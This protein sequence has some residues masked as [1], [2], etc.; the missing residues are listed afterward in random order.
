[1]TD[2]LPALLDRGQLARETGLSRAG[3]DAVFR[4]LD[5][6]HLPGLRKPLVRRQD[7]ERLIVENTYRDGE[8][9]RW[10]RPPVASA[11]II[12]R[13]TE[14]GSRRFEV[15]Y[16][17][18]GRDTRTRYGGRFKTK[19]LAEARRAYI[20]AELAGRRVPDLRP[21]PDGP[22]LRPT[23]AAAAERWLASRL[24]LGP[25]S[26]SARRSACRRLVADLGERDPASLTVADV[27][28]L[29]AA[30]AKDLTPETVKAYITTL[31][32]VLDHA[33]IEPNPARDRRVRLP[34]IVREEPKPPTRREVD[35]LVEALP[36]RFRLPV[37]LMEATGL[38]VGEACAATWGDLDVRDSRLRV[39][40]T[41]TKG[42]SGGQRWV[43][44]PGPLLE[45]LLASTPPDDR[46]RE[47]RIFA[48]V[49]TDSVRRAMGR[50]CERAG[51]A[52]YGPHTLRHRRLSLWHAAG[53]PARELA[54]RAGHSR[55]SMSLDTYSH[56]LVDDDDEWP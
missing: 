40:R 42:R 21:L 31:R 2:A 29:V 18:G 49:T 51:I 4:A 35:A 43:Q 19:R 12:A 11:W 20:A 24:D 50:A 3:V 16:R 10:R 32:A 46:G 13:T 5:V 8:R 26:Q 47:A 33:G 39:S 27:Q 25:R 28:D 45:E 17:L 36:A 53:V 38:R 37:R 23:L 6:V 52:S 7:V 54:T 30:L 34:R 55:P 1:V 48:G 41:R 22:V 14:G 9:V 56:V 15:R 44:I